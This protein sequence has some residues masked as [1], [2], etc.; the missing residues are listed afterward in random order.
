MKILLTGGNGFLAKE[1]AESFKQ[2]QVLNI[3]RSGPNKIDLTKKKEVENFFHK[4]GYFDYIVHTAIKGGKK[5][6]IDDYTV[7]VDNLSMFRNIVSNKDK[8]GKMF[9]FCSGAAFRG[10]GEIKNAREEDIVNFWPKDFYGLSKN[11]ISREILNLDFIYNFR[12]FGCFG[13]NEP[14]T[15][16]IKSCFNRIKDGNKPIIHQD[17]QMDFFYSKDL[18]NVL[19]FYIKNQ[20]DDLPKDLNLVYPEKIFLSDILTIICDLTNTQKDFIFNQS[21]EGESYTG[22]SSKIQ[23]IPL[24]LVGLEKGIEEYKKDVFRV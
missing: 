14:E 1:I 13:K 9:N 23:K 4:K 8:F 21:G 7:L 2:Y 17:R 3:S 6:V 19:N 20:Q 10:N 16:F 11:I 12:I 24:K 15:R 18:I 22:D 5:E